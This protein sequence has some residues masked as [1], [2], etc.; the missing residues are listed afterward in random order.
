MSEKAILGQQNLLFKDKE[1]ARSYKSI[2]YNNKPFLGD[3]KEFFNFV[4]DSKMY[5]SLYAVSYVASYDYAVN[6]LAKFDKS[7]LIL[8][9]EE[10]A[11]RFFS[12]NVDEESRIIEVF[13]YN[14]AY[15]DKINN[16]SL[17]IRYIIGNETVHTK[18]YI[19]EGD[20]KSIAIVGS[21]NFTDQAFSGKRKQFEDVIAYDSDYNIEFVNYYKDRFNYLYRLSSN[22]IIEQ[23]KKKV[24]I[25]NNVISINSGV[26]DINKAMSSIISVENSDVNVNNIKDGTIIAGQNNVINVL[27]GTNINIVYTEEEKVDRVIQK[28]T[29]LENIDANDFRDK[30]EEEKREM[31]KRIVELEQIQNTLDISTKKT[32]DGYILKIDKNI[33][34]YKDK[35]FKII[36]KV[37]GAKK[38]DILSQRNTFIYS[39]NDDI[40]YK[41]NN[42]QP[43]IAIPYG[44]N[45]DRDKLKDSIQKIDNFVKSYA[46]FSQ[47]NIGDNTLARVYEAILFAFTSPFIWLFRQD[48][49]NE[50]G[51]E[52]VA[53]I[54]IV[55]ILGGE[56]N[57][58]KTKLLNT[59]NQLLGNNFQVF[60]YNN[61]YTR[62]Q[63]WMDI[64]FESNNI[65]PV[66]VD[67]VENSFFRS[68]G[69]RQ[70][71]H[72]TNNNIKPSPCIIGTSN[73]NFSVESQVAR[74]I[75]YLHF[76]SSF[77][78]D[79][80]IK[81][82]A[83]R[84]FDENVGTLDDTV[85][86]H[87]IYLF[88]EH[89]K[90]GSRLY[91]EHDHLYL[92]REIFKELYTYAGLKVPAVFPNKPYSDYYSKGRS[93]WLAMFKSNRERFRE[94][95][96]GKDTYYVI[97]M[98]GLTPNAMVN[99]KTKLPPSIVK[100]SDIPLEVHKD[101]FLQFIGQEG[102]IKR[103]LVKFIH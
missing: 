35:I 7:I 77:P 51:T 74:R 72:Y 38:D 6:I 55:M 88:T 83:N 37:K 20:K 41:V 22:E 12:L 28:L 53:E 79:K 59:I 9:E 86:K 62:N 32:K 56:A 47:G 87:F 101:K 61:L 21:A 103:I 84:Y 82:D 48:I 92:A 95:K 49:Y 100:S 58:G 68:A 2:L 46:L 43:N 11:K 65:F 73:I 52:K 3:V 27:D 33:Q 57:T 71:K 4:I 42:D 96:D 40:I 67:E 81:A 80:K 26:I 89:I 69:E 54:P 8:G 93:Q 13:K 98:T 76:D 30:I 29:N 36:A 90:A 85:F 75:Y 45:V 10:N 91:E 102:R 60:I 39:E 16:G 66:L 34:K 25:D 1:L 5:K 18:L 94:I 15:M 50:K 97:D 31:E 24:N 70:I 19:F 23:I 44:E 99:L 14:T 78:E 17:E 64:V 63:T